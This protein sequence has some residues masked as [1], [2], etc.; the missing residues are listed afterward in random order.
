MDRRPRAREA[1]G[2]RE[3]K[4]SRKLAEKR[5]RR[6]ERTARKKRG[7]DWTPIVYVSIIVTL[8]LGALVFMA[9]VGSHGPKSINVAVGA[10]QDVGEQIPIEPARHIPPGTPAQYL[11]DPPTSGQHYSVRGEAPL[12]WGFYAREYPPEDWVHNLEHG[13]VVI[14]YSCP[15]PQPTGGAQLIE[16]DL[17]CPDSQSPVQDF[18]SSAPPDAL[19]QEVK[20]VATPYPVPGH[21][22]AMVAWGWRLFMDSWDSSLAERFYEAHVDNGPERIP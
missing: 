4:S 8:A 6:E 5:L 11:T 22:Y 19:F 9:Y 10:Q 3:T 17:S 2:R 12:P 15:Q 13:G 20:I 18:I 21:R 1:A 16:T 7:R 14:L